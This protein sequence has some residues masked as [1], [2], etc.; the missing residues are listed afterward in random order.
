[1]NINYKKHLLINEIWNE[2]IKNISPDKKKFKN[3]IF[4]NFP[5][6]ILINH[7]RF[8]YKIKDEDSNFKNDRIIIDKSTISND[9]LHEV[10]NIFR[11]K[12]TC[13]GLDNIKYKD[14]VS[15]QDTLNNFIKLIN[16]IW[17]YSIIPED[18]KVCTI[19]TL[20]KKGD[21]NNINNYRGI[22]LINFGLKFYL[23]IIK[24][25]LTKFI[26]SE[27]IL[28]DTQFG[29]RKNKSCLM[30]IEILYKL[31][32]KYDTLYLCFIDLNKAF[33]S[34]N[35]IK[36]IK[37]LYKYKIDKCLI[38]KIKYLYENIKVVILG[39]DNVTSKMFK[40]TRGIIQGCPLSPI[41][42]I[43]FLADIQHLYKNY[44]TISLED[45]FINTLEYADDIVIIAK[46]K[47]ELNNK[48]HIFNK[49]LQKK[50]IQIN[51]NKTK[52]LIYGDS[53]DSKFEWDENKFINIVNEVNYLGFY[54]NN[55]SRTIS[56]NFYTKV[57]ILYKL[58]NEIICIINCNFNNDFKKQINIIHN[59][60]FS[61]FNFGLKLANYMPIEEL[62]KVENLQINYLN[63]IIQK[64][65][66][67][68]TN[69][70]KFNNI[71]N[72]HI[73]NKL[74]FNYKK[75]ELYRFNM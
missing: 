65:I 40:P 71:I 16:I 45:K 70:I 35:R 24:Y 74:L 39:N 53:N 22:G 26:E 66:N 54:F 32:Q 14:I 17:K 56:K 18:W 12:K 34:I 5:L 58:L 49:Y 75:N 69:T 27:N 28:S 46:S 33:D 50:D 48:L 21:P 57:D 6:E 72:K 64:N 36:L 11:K 30:N 9:C 25:K 29:F 20:F 15:S 37:E 31:I 62:I 3:Y 44:K 63:H 19:I 10:M 7:Y 13:T 47:T 1:M 42:F 51:L 61:R 67:S 59:I 2:I 68:V 55:Y 43:T 23:Y 38:R 52:I 4:V 60:I 8:L 73:N 41:L